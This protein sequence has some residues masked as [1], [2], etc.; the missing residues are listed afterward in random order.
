LE[1]GRPC[2]T[3][4]MLGSCKDPGKGFPSPRYKALMKSC[5]LV[6]RTGRC[7]LLLSLHCLCMSHR[8]WLPILSNCDRVWE[9][10][11]DYGRTEDRKSVGEL[12]GDLGAI[13]RSVLTLPFETPRS[14]P[15]KNIP[16]SQEMHLK[17]PLIL[18][19]SLNLSHS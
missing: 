11:V 19:R 3:F 10:A 16:F 15:P 7:L 12:K 17:I 18:S 4:M 2:E 9:A 5:I 8:A 13:I 1:S 14:S 6:H